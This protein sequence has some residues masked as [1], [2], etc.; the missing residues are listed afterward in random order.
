M[1]ERI[2]TDFGYMDRERVSAAGRILPYSFMEAVQAAEAGRTRILTSAEHQRAFD[3]AD[4]LRAKYAQSG[5]Y[6]GLNEADTLLLDLF[7]IKIA[8]AG[9]AGAREI[10]A[11]TVDVNDYIIH[12]VNG[13]DRRHLYGYKRYE[14]FLPELI[15]EVQRLQSEGKVPYIQEIDGNPNSPNYGF[16]LKVGEE[17]N[18]KY[19]DAIFWFRLPYSRTAGALSRAAST[20]R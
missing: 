2:A 17:P 15:R 12:D 4:K 16:A 20:I 19:H 5:D 7:G 13:T 8:P 3:F 1:Q 11:T 6:K 10:T 18:P 9:Y 14:R